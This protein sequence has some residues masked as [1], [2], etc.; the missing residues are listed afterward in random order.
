MNVQYLLS[1]DFSAVWEYR[2]QLARG[3][4]V[5]IGLLLLSA[6]CGF[7]L[8]AALAVL[9]QSKRRLF[10]LFSTTYVEIWR[11][12]PLIV[13]LFWIHFAL[14]VFTGFTTSAILSG[15]VALVGNVT[16]YFAEIMRA[17]IQ[18][19]DRGQW[20]AGRALGLPARA[21][22]QKIIFPQALKIVIPPLTS[23]SVSLLKA[24]SI[25]SVLSIND[26]MRVTTSLSNYTFRPVEL[27][28]A[29]ALIYFLTGVGLSKLGAYLERRYSLSLD[30]T[31]RSAG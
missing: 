19:V 20:E 2:S 23:L 29:V 13:Q 16:A 11:N 8:G 15:L 5:T 4:G 3:F 26:L 27:F 10:R 12:T 28:T 30:V 21:L 31:N 1:L 22:W 14:P 24:T 7:L 25:L 6:V 9:G 17:G 18:S